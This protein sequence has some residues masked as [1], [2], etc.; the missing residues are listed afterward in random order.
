[1]MQKLVIKGRFP[2][3]NEIIAS[4]KSHPMVYAKEK[5]KLTTSVAL[6]AKVQK[7]VPVLGSVQVDFYWYEPNRR[8]DP[9]NIQVGMKFVLDG[10]VL[11]GILPTDGWGTIKGLSSRFLLDPENPRVEV[12]I[13]QWRE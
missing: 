10:L 9:D 6:L 4:A 3:L 5:K 12:Q 1:M 2:S 7:L 8:R 11:G 13:E